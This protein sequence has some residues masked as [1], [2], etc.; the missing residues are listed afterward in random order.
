VFAERLIVLKRC[1]FSGQSIS[2]AFIIHFFT[3]SPSVN[4]F[5][6]FAIICEIAKLA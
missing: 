6:F 5:D 1:C 3:Y 4:G 2:A